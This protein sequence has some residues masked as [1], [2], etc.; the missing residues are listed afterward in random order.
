MPTEYDPITAKHYAA[1]RPCL[2]LP[3]L[4]KCIKN[5]H[6]ALGLDIGCGTGQS[7]LALT[8]FCNKVIAIDPSESMLQNAMPHNQIE[9]QHC[10]GQD[11]QFEANIFDCITFAGSLFYAKSQHLLNEVEK[12]A[13]PNAQVIIY[14]FMVLLDPTLEQLGVTPPSNN[15]TITL[16]LTSPI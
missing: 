13:K 1:Y 3:I 9:Y 6:Y 4:Q 15:W 16:R 2:H 12:V 14:D 5:E 7:A 8:N 11:L 10:N